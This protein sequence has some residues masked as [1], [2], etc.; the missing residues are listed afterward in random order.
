M[1]QLSSEYKTWLSDLKSKIRSAQIKAAIA[2]NSALIEFYWE[3]GKMISEK[4]AQWGTK[5]LETLSKD[6]QDE[7]PEMKG[8]SVT[9]LKYCKLFYNY[10]SFRPQVEDE[11]NNSPQVGDEISQQLVVQIPWGHIKL[12]IGKIKDVREAQFYIE[13]TVLKF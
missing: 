8:F 4:Q 9:N 6:L 1:K 3:L 10:F 7:F 5:F 11:L 2:V 13:Q 12:I